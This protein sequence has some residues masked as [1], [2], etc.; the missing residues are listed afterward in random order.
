MR[1]LLITAGPTCEP[2]DGAR[3]LGN[4]SSGRLGCCIAQQ[5]AIKGHEATLLLGSTAKLPAAHPRLRVVRF[6]TARELAALLSEHWPSHDVLV[7]AAAVAD[8]TVRGGER[9]GK[10]RRDSLRILELSPTDDLVAMAAADSR[11][12]QR[13]IAFA[14][15]EPAELEASARHKLQAKHVDA[16]VANP[17]S[18]MDAESIAAEIFCS[19]GR[20]FTPPGELSKPA[21]AAWLL[22]HLAEILLPDPGD[23]TLCGFS[24]TTC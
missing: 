8:C 9:K 17:M 5:A 4:R 16:I 21:F 11:S 6:R 7:M 1:R 14:L 18:T 10:V 20:V 3:F 19:D 24:A 2:I 23:G 15:E 13:I 22:E 12:D